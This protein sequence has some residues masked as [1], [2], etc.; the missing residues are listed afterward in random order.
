MLQFHV[1]TLNFR[2]EN[3][4][5][6]RVQGRL[7]Q[8]EGSGKINGAGNYRFTLITTAGNAA[9]QGQPNSFGLKIW[10]ID[11]LTRAEVVSYDNQGAGKGSAVPAT[12][13]A[14]VL[15]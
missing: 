13:G 1:G 14:I 8:F 2:S 7:A 5:P 3:I 10:H 12:Q 4:K 9:G 6:L 15:Q 11:P